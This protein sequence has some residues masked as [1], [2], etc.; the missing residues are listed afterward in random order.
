MH[1]MDTRRTAVATAMVVALGFGLAGCGDG[2]TTI[3]TGDGT[4]SVDGDADGGSLTI[5]SS[6]GSVTVN[7]EAD[8]E[9][10]EG[11]PEAVVVPEG[12][13][14]SAAGRFDGADGTQ[15]N[16]AVTYSDK[17]ADDVNS[18][19]NATLTGAGY[20]VES[21]STVGSQ[22][23]ASYT[24]NGQSVVTTVSEQDGG[25]FLSVAIAPEI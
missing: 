14:I 21:E 12:G 13:S 10:P 9:L 5:D 4:I 15:W 24:G 23:L 25:V 17:S 22:V 3:S 19:I 11:W 2:E 8:G 1:W 18:E 6:E 16:I 7:T 20:T